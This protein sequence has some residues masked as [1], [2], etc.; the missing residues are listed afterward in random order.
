MKFLVWDT[1]SQEG[2]VAACEA[3]EGTGSW[4]LVSEFNF[5]V[6]L[7]HSERL[8]WGIDQ[9]LHSARWELKDLDFFGV[10]VGP[11]SF[12]G[13]RIAVTT[14]RTLASTMNKPLIGV[15]S[16]AALVHPAAQWVAQFEPQATLMAATDA[17]KGELFCHW[18]E[19][20]K[21]SEAGELSEA[22]Q[23]S[24]LTHAAAVEVLAEKALHSEHRWLVMGDAT[25]RYPELWDS[26]PSER[27]ITLPTHWA[28]QTQA[29]ALG[30]LAWKK[31]Q[32]GRSFPFAEVLPQYRR[33]SSAELKRQSASS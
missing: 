32:S 15:S 25:V 29:R 27:R 5:N 8:L 13:L 28:Q 30:Q 17:C 11:G 33:A 31:F 7:T 23:E 21:L 20:Q 18:G 4:K 14:A 6:G 22:A 10:G 2:S 1:S 3:E 26:L 16:L 24:S 19:A 9:V 12:T